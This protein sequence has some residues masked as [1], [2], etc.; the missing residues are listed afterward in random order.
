MSN[1]SDPKY[2][3][4]YT[5]GVNYIPY[6]GDNWPNNAEKGY[7]CGTIPYNDAPCL[8]NTSSSWDTT[9]RYN[10]DQY[11]PSTFARCCDGPIINITQPVVDENDPSYG[12]TCLAYCQVDFSRTMD[13]RGGADFGEYWRCITNQTSPDSSLDSGTDSNG[14]DIYG[15]VTC[16]WIDTSEHDQCEISI[17]IE[18]TN[19]APQATM[20]PLSQKNWSSPTTRM[21]ASTTTWSACPL[22]TTPSSSTT[23]DAVT[24]PTTSQS[25]GT[26]LRPREAHITLSN[27]VTFSLVATFVWF[28]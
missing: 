11:A 12:A 25:A 28:T 4:G 24:S 16:G 17:G 27:I 15:S 26:C 20:Y 21:G 19:T 7:I 23:S 5:V 2:G 13:L 8:A 6:V 10:V 14:E 1:S 18:R 9:G 22:Q 3:S